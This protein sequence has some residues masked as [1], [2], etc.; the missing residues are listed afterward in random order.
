MF[1][2]HVEHYET[3]CVYIYIYIYI[4][5]YTHTHTHI[6]VAVVLLLATSVGL[7]G[8]SSVFVNIGLMMVY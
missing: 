8:P 4:Y 6:Y 2:N 7:N 3:P 5:I 1:F